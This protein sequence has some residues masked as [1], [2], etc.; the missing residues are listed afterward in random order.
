[1]KEKLLK[2]NQGKAKAK[3]K[4][5]VTPSSGNIFADMGLPNPEERLLKAKLARLVNKAIAGKGWTQTYTAQVLG[6]TQP[7][8]SELSRGRLKNFSVERLLYFL[9]K[10]DRKVT[11][12]VGGERADSPREEIVIAARQQ[13]PAQAQAR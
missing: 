9:S 13:P 8:V 4:I 3:G 6:I 2:K 5:K 1:M 11:I 12:T 7:D 10:L